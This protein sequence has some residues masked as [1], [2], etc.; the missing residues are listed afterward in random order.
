ME[1]TQYCSVNLRNIPLSVNSF[2]LELPKD[3]AERD[4]RI[5]DFALTRFQ[6]LNKSDD[7]PSLNDVSRDGR[8]SILV[9]C[10]AIKSYGTASVLD[11]TTPA[12]N[13]KSDLP[14]LATIPYKSL[15]S[16]PDNATGVWYPND[17]TTMPSRRS[18]QLGKNTGQV[19][20]SFVYENGQPVVFSSDGSTVDTHLM[21]EFRLQK[22]AGR[23]LDG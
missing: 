15:V 13:F 17:D 18:L 11:Y 6:L 22:V 9:L 21:L 3:Q 12:N 20:I 5:S 14:I 1:F 10:D 19:K 4:T 16:P 7:Q 8:H 23:G 2:V